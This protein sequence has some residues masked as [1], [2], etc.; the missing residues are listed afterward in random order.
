[1]CPTITCVEGLSE[2]EAEEEAEG[3]GMLDVALL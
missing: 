2:A 3:E 1:M